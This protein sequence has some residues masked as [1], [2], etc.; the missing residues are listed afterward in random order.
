MSITLLRLVGCIVVVSFHTIGGTS[1]GGAFLFAALAVALTS[2]SGDYRG[3]IE[4]RG[5]RLVLP[6][7]FW[8]AVYGAVKGIHVLRHGQSLSQVFPAT[9]LLCGT[10]VHLWYLPYAFCGAVATSFGMRCIRQR[11]VW[12]AATG[13]LVF[14]AT[15][16]IGHVHTAPFGQWILA[17][18]ALALGIVF[19][20]L[21]REKGSAADVAMAV[22]TVWVA[23]A[24]AYMW[25]GNE[26]EPVF[27]GATLLGSLWCIR[28]KSFEILDKWAELTYGVYLLHPMVLWYT[29]RPGWNL[30]PVIALTVLICGAITAII[31]NTWIKRFV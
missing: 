31:K 30:V 18:P 13:A 27:I 25:G 26:I 29:H 19:N 21:R 6:W 2:T 15:M 23:C 4:N 1:P 10:S 11:W 3:L 5:K 24:M 17:V 7:L 28:A 20:I 14:A 9:T 12:V 16:A 8:S 22:G